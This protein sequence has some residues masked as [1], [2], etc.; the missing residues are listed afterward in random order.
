MYVGVRGSTGNA[1]K[2]VKILEPSEFYTMRI[3]G[4]D[5]R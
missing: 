2:I 1:G 3:W 4:N 5:V